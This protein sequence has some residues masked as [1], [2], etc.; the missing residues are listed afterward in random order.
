MS[1]IESI[2]Q[3]S[4]PMK[5]A[6]FERYKAE[7]SNVIVPPKGISIEALQRG[8]ARAMERAQLM[9]YQ[10]DQKLYHRMSTVPQNII[11]PIFEVGFIAAY[12]MGKDREIFWDT[13][14]GNDDLL[15]QIS[16]EL[17]ST[18]TKTVGFC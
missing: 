2:T 10:P 18:V 17:S 5:S 11:H 1:S 14:I 16:G 15:G 9:E 6:I 3:P 7:R 13:N 4:L 12:P 8:R